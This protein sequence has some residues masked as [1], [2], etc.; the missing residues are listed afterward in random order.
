[1]DQ[2][3][4]R[5]GAREAQQLTCGDRLVQH[6]VDRTK[7][8][9]LTELRSRAVVSAGRS[10]RRDV[11]R[12]FEHFD[13]LFVSIPVTGNG[14]DAD[15]Q[16][17][18]R[19]DVFD[20]TVEVQFA[21]IH[22][23]VISDLFVNSR[24][25]MIRRTVAGNHDVRAHFDFHQFFFASD[26]GG[27][28]GQHVQRGVAGKFVRNTN[29]GTDFTEFHGRIGSFHITEGNFTQFADVEG[30]GSVGTV[31]FDNLTD[32]FNALNRARTSNHTVDFLN[33]VLTGSPA[34][35]VV[36]NITEHV[37]GTGVHG[38]CVGSLSQRD[39]IRKI[40]ASRQ[41]Q[42]DFSHFIT[43]QTLGSQFFRFGFSVEFD[44]QI[45]VVAGVQTVFRSRAR[46]AHTGIARNLVRS[47]FDASQNVGQRLFLDF[48]QRFHCSCSPLFHDNSRFTGRIDFKNAGQNN[49]RRNRVIAGV[50]TSFDFADFARTGG[51]NV[52]ADSQ[53]TVVSNARA[54]FKS[55]GR[56]NT[57]S[58]RAQVF[59]LF[60]QTQNHIAIGSS[61]NGVRR[62]RVQSADGSYVS[63]RKRGRGVQRVL[64]FGE[65]LHRNSHCESSPI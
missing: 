8:V 3:F 54:K 21:I 57:L 48:R 55:D 42:G 4:N 56:Q 27:E 51:N 58:L 28:R 9:P 30:F 39:L 62:G 47:V 64:S 29:T 26:A 14:V 43:G 1:M 18:H 52:V 38:E 59:N 46:Q 16:F 13:P 34:Q 50:A 22:R 33:V 45:Q 65:T 41:V 44:R 40:I 31:Q 63:V 53:S 12:R 19:N 6:E 35:H 20:Q 61:F 10:V 24:G 36:N 15:A 2:F 32:Q 17:I 25:R 7:R 49:A 37:A 11:R 5:V 60:N 23:A